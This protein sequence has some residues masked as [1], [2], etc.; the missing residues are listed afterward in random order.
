MEGFLAHA[1]YGAL[2]F[3]G[4][5]EACC[6]PVSSEITFGFAG[7]LAYQ[8]HFNLVLAIII[9]SLAEL[10]GSYVSYAVGRRGG[11]QAVERFGRFA[12]I[13]P[14]DIDRVERFFTGRGEWTVAV[15]R[16]LP[17]VRPF[18]SVVAGMIEIP[19]LRFGLLS[20]AGTLVWATAFSLTGYAIGSAWTRVAH[21][22]SIGGYAAAAVLIVAVAAL[23]A[24]RVRSLRKH[25]GAGRGPGRPPA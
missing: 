4:F 25:D 18:I 14:A 3:F 6:I 10:A 7:V 13:R 16:A 23:V 22:F 8:G 19:S 1:G 9:G 21:A 24:H 11:R 12:L 5:I 17:V 15:G 20:L 2:V